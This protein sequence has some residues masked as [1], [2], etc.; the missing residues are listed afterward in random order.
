VPEAPK[1][2][3]FLDLFQPNERVRTFL[4]DFHG[5]ALT[6]ETADQVFVY[7]WG[8]GANGKSTFLE[9]LAG[10]MGPYAH[11]MNAESFIGQTQSGDKATPDFAQLHGVRWLRVSELPAG[12]PL[13]E[14]LIK[15]LTGGDV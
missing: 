14:S 4:R 13:K 7:H 8:T 10:V 15:G 12:E 1:W 3:E 5:Y 9:A 2:R 6:A 11:A